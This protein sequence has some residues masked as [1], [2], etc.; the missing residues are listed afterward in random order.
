MLFSNIPKDIL[1]H[2]L[3]NK[4]DCTKQSPVSKCLFTYFVHV[5]IDEVLVQIHRCVL[6]CIHSMLR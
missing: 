6:Q 5:L 3:Y 1:I 2:G 4:V